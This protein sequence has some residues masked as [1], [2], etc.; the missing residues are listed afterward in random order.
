[1]RRIELAQ[2][3]AFAAVAEHRN[4]K[5]AAAQLGISPPSLS[6][7]VRGLEE[8]FGV[9]L[10]NRTTRSVALTE[11]GEQLLGHLGAVFAGV[12]KACDAVN[13]FRDTPAGT[14]RLSVDP[15]AAVSVVAPLVARFAL[16]YPAIRLDVVV[17]GQRRD[18]I[19]ERFDAGICFGEAVALDMISVAAGERFSLA[20]VAAPD[21]LAR[22]APPT[23]PQ[24]LARHNCI[25]TPWTGAASGGAWR[26]AQGG[27]QHD[28]AVEGSLSV[29]DRELALRAALDGVGVVQLPDMVVSPFVA[30]GR[31]V[32]LLED[33]WLPPARCALYYA[34]SRHVPTK[35][36][37]LIDF[38]R[39]DVK[40]AA[41]Q[42]PHQVEGGIAPA[43]A[44]SF[45]R[46]AAARPRAAARR[47]RA[48]IAVVP[49]A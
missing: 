16:A 29:N 2:L 3:T 47:A 45:M 18:I 48:D 5:R 21:Y 15:V 32:P 38:L 11:A 1:M 19:G 42:L 8:L 6:A 26:F 35:L 41:P 43:A 22:R 44:R 12:E 27:Q 25:R 31:L 7:C 10:L 46:D 33:W 40:P 17:D 34:C 14:L 13:A 28:V 36:R 49:A 4:F 23:R 37:A 20:T 9:R 24:D 39:R 30:G